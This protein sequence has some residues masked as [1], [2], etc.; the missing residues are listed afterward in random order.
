MMKNIQELLEAIE[1]N[2][3]DNWK[4]RKIILISRANVWCPRCRESGHCASECIKPA[5]RRIHYVKQEDEV[6]LT[7]PEEE[8]D[9]VVVPIFQVH[10]TYGTGK[11]PQ[12]P[13][14]TNI[15]LRPVLT[16]VG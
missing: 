10:P 6:Y 1:V 9:E 15:V 16:R 11:T 12:Q 13:M 8:E 3:A 5:Q 4:P 2:L 14:M 7:I